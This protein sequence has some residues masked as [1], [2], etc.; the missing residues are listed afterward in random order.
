VP[1]QVERLLRSCLEKDS[2]LRL[3]DIGD[4]KLLLQDRSASTRSVEIRRSAWI[5]WSLAALFFVST[6]AVA[7]VH[8]RVTPAQTGTLR[9]Q[10]APPGKST[11]GAF[12]L[13]PDGRY[14]A[15]IAIE[16]SRSR[17]WVRPLNAL[18]AQPLPG[19]D[20]ANRTRSGLPSTGLT[21]LSLQFPTSGYWT[22]FVVCPLV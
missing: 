15:M 9:F 12:R 19:T 8:F 17:L 13:S 3:R 2:K 11:I 4:A 14:L 16:G 6:A 21:G 22:L 20:G 10:V 7:F 1:I 5:A 18:E